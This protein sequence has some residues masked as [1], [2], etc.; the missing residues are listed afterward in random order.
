MKHTIVHK[1]DS[2][3]SAVLICPSPPTCTYACIVLLCYHFSILSFLWFHLIACRVRPVLNLGERLYNAGNPRCTE[4]TERKHAFVQITHT[5]IWILRYSWKGTIAHASHMS[6][7]ASGVINDKNVSSMP[8]WGQGQ[9]SSMI[10]A[11]IV[12][13]RSWQNEFNTTGLRWQPHHPLAASEWK[14][15]KSV[16]TCT[17]AYP[18]GVRW[19]RHSQGHLST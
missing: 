4:R 13:W 16:C 18:H 12:A 10:G 2:I 19:V 7:N 9:D 15:Q 14:T 6:I 17:F 8:H 3:H 1:P 5:Q 11:S